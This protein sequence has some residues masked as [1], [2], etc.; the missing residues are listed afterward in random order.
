MP[1]LDQTRVQ[2]AIDKAYDTEVAN[3]FKIL[4]QNLIEVASG[5]GSG[6]FTRAEQCVGAFA[7]NMRQVAF[8]YEKASEVAKQIATTDA[9]P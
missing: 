4:I 5:A 1:R 7:R 3:L 2:E 6:G 9:K 8:A